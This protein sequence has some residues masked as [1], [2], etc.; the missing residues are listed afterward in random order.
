[1]PAFRPV[2]LLALVLALPAGPA[3]AADPVPTGPLPRTVVPTLVRLELKIDPRQE[4]FS[5]TVR[6]EAEVKQATDT[7]WMHG[8][9][10]TIGKTEAVLADGTRVALRTQLAD[11]SGVLKMRAARALPAGRATIE[12]AYDAPY[13]P[14]MGAYRVK[15][16]GRDYVV[17]QME[18]TGA[19]RAFPGFDEP[20]FK[21][22]WEVA[23]IVP[24]DDVAV[25]N[26][27]E[28]NS[29]PLGDGWKKVSFRRTEALPSY[30]I[31]FGVGPW[32]V[33]QGPD[34]PASAVRAVPLPLRAI[35][36][37]GQGGRVREA[38][39]R[40]PR[41][42]AALEDYFGTPYAY[43]KLDSLTGP[44]LGGMEN[45]GLI[46]YSDLYMFANADS[47]ASQ[48]KRSHMTIAHEIAHQWVGN[49]VTMRWWDDLWLSEGFA[50]WMGVKLNTM[51]DPQSHLERFLLDGSLQTMANDSLAGAPAIRA[52]VPSGDEAFGSYTKIT[53]Y[54]GAAITGMLER[55]LG[56]AALREGMRAYLRAHAGGNAT[57]DD[58][59][60]AMV[61]HSGERADAVRRILRGFTEQPGVPLVQVDVDCEGDKPALLLR[62]SRYLPIGV[63]DPAVRQWSIPMV[64]RY[65]DGGEVREQ[66]LLFEGAK[67]RLTLA[68][69]R[70]CPDWVMPN[71]YAAGYYRYALAPRWRQAL[72]S[73]FGRLDAQEQRSDTDSLLAA[74]DAG[75]L[76]T[77]G[78]LATLPHLMDAT[79]SETV[80]A[81]LDRF[82]WI[83]ANLFE[84]GDEDARTR[85][86]QEIAALYRP[87]LDALGDAPVPGEDQAV[88]DLRIRLLGFYAKTLE[89]K[90]VRAALAA[91]GRAVLGVDGDAGPRPDAAP[92]DLRE[93]ALLVAVQDGGV[94][95]FDVAE[96]RLRASQD[97]TLRTQLVKALG[98]AGD[99]RLMAR[100]QALAL[101]P[102][103]LNDLEFFA[104]LRR[105]A[106][107]RAQ[108]EQFR[109]W[110]DRD[111][112]AL[113]GRVAFAGAYVGALYATGMC[114]GEE[115]RRFETVFGPRMR[116]LEEGL[117]VLQHALD[118][119]RSCAT[120]R[121][122][123]RAK[124][125]A[126]MPEAAGA[127]GAP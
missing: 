124:G 90:A 27:A 92:A 54:K 52:P 35:T 114:S 30:L 56:E 89:D 42:V 12:I 28:T 57:G 53:Y 36:P 19:R 103:V 115:V 87:R 39:A 63:D 123:R 38:L 101:E 80:T 104:L 9:D 117:P 81:P 40:M 46:V 106:D 76:S 118:V 74:Y 8:R 34:V 75:Q 121:D 2:L 108:R 105:M 10:L 33:V 72:S 66:S 95:A 79:A 84:D 94:E 83:D 120:L 43:G 17:T 77:S 5:G 32:D 58:W 4:R 91:Q 71:A 109:T 22:P 93:L 111:F 41:I 15:S 24:E 49:L 13:G 119:A 55:Y 60:E 26:G 65:A 110:I 78:L 1:M 96:R 59:I 45:A 112:D 68:Q 116:K 25:A 85:L 37:K 3:G 21:Q 127:Q 125:T 99:P 16:E 73:A 97:A 11:V 7:I 88:S 50:S 100:R 48:Q 23:L 107:V 86:R 6:I 47:P 31:A 61:A 20:G 122:A 102:G 98:G 18:P 44:D 51:L 64:V 14:F 29:E 82:E 126:S 70:T 113:G 62:Q 67:A 69:A